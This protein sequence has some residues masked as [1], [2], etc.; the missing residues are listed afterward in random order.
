MLVMTKITKIS[1]TK[2]GFSRV[3]FNCGSFLQHGFSL[4]ELMIA[5]A[6][7]GI[8]V[9][10]AIPNFRIWIQN[11]HIRTAAES[12]QNGLQV[13]RAEAVKRN[14]PVQFTLGLNSGWSVGCSIPVP[15]N[16]GDG[17]DDCPAVIQSRSFNEG[18]SADIT[19]ITVPAASNIV[20]FDNFGRVSLL[21]VPFTQVDLNSATLAELDSR[22]LRV[23]LGTGGNVRMCDPEPTLPVTD[24]RR[25]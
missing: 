5:V 2:S 10:L 21:P 4:V 19:V 23:T 9:S 13:A 17:I 16:D 14:T 12:I 22:N 25:C 15:D 3:C 24:P 7:L 8:V 20:E 1:K 6:L 11:T 18:S